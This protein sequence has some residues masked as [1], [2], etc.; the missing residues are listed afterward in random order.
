M[1]GRPAGLSND[2]AWSVTGI[3][4]YTELDKSLDNCFYVYTIPHLSRLNQLTL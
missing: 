1:P 4:T 3:S 2:G